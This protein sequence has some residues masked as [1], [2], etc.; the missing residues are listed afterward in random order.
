MTQLYI[1]DKHCLSVEQLK[2]YFTEDLTADSV[3]YY[4]ILDY[5]RYGDISQWLQELGEDELSAKVA[6]IDNTL[7]DSE[8]FIELKKIKASSDCLA[9]F[10]FDKKKKKCCGFGKKCFE[11]DAKTKTVIDNITGLPIK[12]N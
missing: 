5:G 9:C 2:G 12:L 7:S 6:S 11:Y 3:I 8:Y 4:D 10:Y 1:N